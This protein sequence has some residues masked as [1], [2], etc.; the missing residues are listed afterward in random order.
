M[1]H[2]MVSYKRQD[3][4]RVAVLVRALRASGLEVWWDQGLAAGETWREQIQT[5]IDEA[6]CVVVVWSEG[7]TGPDGGFVRDEATRAL[8][9]RLLVPVSID[10]VLP[11]LG[12][13]EVQAINL[14]SWRGGTKD[15]FFLDLVAAC[16]A[17]LTGEPVPPAKGPA[18]R[19]FRR[20][21]AGTVSAL[22]AGA[23]WAIAYNVGG[24]QAAICTVPLGQ[25]LLSD[26]C[27]ALGLGGRPDRDERI[28]WESRPKGDCA[29]LRAHIVRF[30]DG[31]Y[32]RLAADLLAAETVERSPTWSPAP[33]T[34]RGYV[35][36][37]LQTFGTADAAQADAKSRAQADAASLCAPLDA[38]QRLAGVE[39]APIA[40]DCRPGLGGGSVCGL[41]YS[42][43]CR[44]ES[45]A[46]V[47]R[48]GG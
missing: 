46:M 10:N 40:F 9:R 5:A 15:P 39:V 35:R 11:P 30:P 2:V 32:R 25:P 4:P 22:V 7:S 34:A 24:T 27:G 36:Q 6:G 38:N 17:K 43:T 16:R 12:F 26:A 1:S 31:A 23:L 37:S 44:L 19:L 21:R 33:R 45:R 28:A 13:G 42:A 20:L 48:C 47:E 41:D 8:A 14:K 18:T 3:E 29:A